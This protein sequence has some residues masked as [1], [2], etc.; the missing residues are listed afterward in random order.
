MKP[1]QT[2]LVLGAGAFAFGFAGPT[3]DAAPS[4]FSGAVELDFAAEALPYSLLRPATIVI[5]YDPQRIYLTHMLVAALLHPVRA[6]EKSDPAKSLNL[7]PMPGAE[8]QPPGVFI[9]QVF[10]TSKAPEDPKAREELLTLGLG[11][12]EVALMNRI[13]IPN[14][15]QAMKAKARY[16]ELID[17]ATRELAAVNKERASQ[18]YVAALRSQAISIAQETDMLQVELAA[19]D[20][21][22]QRALANIQ[23]S[24]AQLEAAEAEV[25]LLETGLDRMAAL[26]KSGVSS[27]GEL[28][29]AK[30][31][32]ARARAD[33]AQASNNVTIG[34]V[35]LSDLDAQ[36]VQLSTRLE[37]AKAN[38]EDIKKSVAPEGPGT[39]AL[40]VKAAARE[41]ELEVAQTFLQSKL[42]RLQTSIASQDESLM[43]LTPVR[44]ER[45]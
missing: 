15:R 42:E 31:K 10:L 28:R 35:G 2:L 23:T 20:A 8:R 45:W 3:Q 6:M 40:D 4:K 5:R 37:A 12:L 7:L 44:V 32:L 18:S 34:A 14:H 29:D 9:G 26:V 17:D 11:N 21:D 19:V 38:L 22:R 27:N 41:M 25:R 36:Q 39:G 43:Q 1:L 13:S 33:L 16:T 24:Q 30:S